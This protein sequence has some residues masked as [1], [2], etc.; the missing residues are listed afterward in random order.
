MD[1]MIFL[2][3]NGAKHVDW[4]QTTT[5]HNLANVNTNGYKADQVAFRALPVIGDG[6]PT[7]TYVVDNTIGHDMR[8]GSLQA[9]GNNFDFALGG[10][11]FFAVQS[12]AGAEAY[13][14]DGGIVVDNTGTLRNPAG[15]A[16]LGDGGPIVI[17]VGTQPQLMEDGTV[18]AIPQSGVDRTPQ[19]VGKIKLVNPGEKATY[20]AEDGLFRLN[21]GGVA[22]ADPAMQIKPGFLEASNV[23]TI[24]AMVQMINH[25]R[26][27]EMNMKLVSTAD[28]NERSA[29]QI[30]SLNG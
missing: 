10:P 9:T 4:Q 22:D 7:R 18:F 19:N 6:A 27:F 15:L 25:S 2:A 5:A 24:E 28:Q 16:I 14:R 29:T 8:Q 20:K 13:T 23:N 11:G 1:R 17:P 21:A 12:P 3:M 30:L 26:A